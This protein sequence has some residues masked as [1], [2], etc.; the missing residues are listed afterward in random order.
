MK[1]IPLFYWSSIK[2][3]GKQKENYGD[4]LSKYLIEKISGKKVKWVHPKKQAWYNYNKKNF[5]GIGSILAHATKNSIVWGSGIIDQTH[6]IEKAD[7]RAVR[8]PKTRA[9]LLELGFDCPEVY[10]DP[11]LLLPEFYSPEVRKDYKIGIVPHYV[12]YREVKNKYGK[13]P[14]VN[15][16]DLLT[17]N[18]EKTTKEILKCEKIIS[19][20]LH[21]IIVAHAYDIPA[22]F[23]EVSNKIFGDGVK[24]QD[25]FLSVGITN[26]T[27][28][29]ISD[30][31]LNTFEGEN[32]EFLLPNAEVLRKRKTDLHNSCPF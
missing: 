3:E 25:Y 16:I 32:L 21:G 29:I 10:G 4:L 18:I 28:M 11:A 2:F 9:R 6:P 7:F 26:A 13:D 5:L 8:G 31:E 1:E 14:E 23:I 30:T 27:K 19:S 24:F 17:D 22:A 20:S 15:V 12:D